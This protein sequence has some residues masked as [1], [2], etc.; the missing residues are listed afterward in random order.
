MV[1]L[2]SFFARG[3]GIRPSKNLPLGGGW[4]GLEL[5]V[6][7]HYQFSTQT[8]SHKIVC[9]HHC[10]LILNTKPWPCSHCARTFTS[11]LR[12]LSPEV[13]LCV[14]HSWRLGG[15]NLQGLVVMT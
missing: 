5:T 10:L 9:A 8:A 12:Q 6:T 14:G 13:K 11:D 1:V 15:L 7:L 4:S 2:N 3:W